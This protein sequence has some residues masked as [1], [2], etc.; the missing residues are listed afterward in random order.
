MDRVGLDLNKLIPP[1]PPPP[2]PPSHLRKSEGS[3]FEVE[4]AKLELSANVSVVRLLKPNAEL[5]SAEELEA[6]IRAFVK[7][8]FEKHGIPFE[9]LSPEDAQAKI[10]AG[11]EFSP[12]AVS[13]R[14]LDFVKGFAEAE[15]SF[16]GKLPEISY[17]T[18]D[19][20]RKG[21]DEL[22]APP[23]APAVDATA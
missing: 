22:F 4:A 3:S 20:V 15:A 18:I 14:I 16:G 2:K 6:R 1:G 17:T 9:E 13:K 19:L 12:E 5:V 7:D 21:L 11:G 10:D 23:P 8:V